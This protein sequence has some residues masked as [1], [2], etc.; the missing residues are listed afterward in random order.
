MRIKQEALNILEAGL[1]KNKMKEVTVGVSSCACSDKYLQP[2][3]D[4]V[5]RTKGDVV[6][7]LMPIKGAISPVSYPVC[8]FCHQNSCLPFVLMLDKGEDVYK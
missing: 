1:D 4:I 8:L 3:V 2:Q 5:W 6:Y 7:S